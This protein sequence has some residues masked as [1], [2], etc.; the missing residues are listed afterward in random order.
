T[1][2]GMMEMEKSLEHGLMTGTHNFL[3]EIDSYFASSFR[4]NVTEYE[5]E[6]QADIIKYF[7][8]TQL[9]EFTSR[10]VP[11][12]Y[13]Y[14][15][16][17]SQKD[18]TSSARI[19][20]TSTINREIAKQAVSILDIIEGQLRSYDVTA[21]P[22]IKVAELDDGRIIIEWIFD[23]FRTGFNLELNPDESG[24]FLISDRYTGDIRSSGYLKG[25]KLGSLIRSL[26]TLVLNN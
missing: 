22:Q 1:I 21:L 18:I 5:Q 4:R 9:Q 7:L 15:R 13:I 25:L 24:Y 19:E 12:K 16:I 10:E 11:P 26:L 8:L 2:P 23:H 17:Q 20:L 6:K 3:T 14:S